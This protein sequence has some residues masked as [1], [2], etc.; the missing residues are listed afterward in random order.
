VSLW[1]INKLSNPES[2][3]MKKKTWK[4]PIIVSVDVKVTED[5]KTELFTKKGK[6]HEPFKNGAILIQPNAKSQYE[7]E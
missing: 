5:E 1:L 3:F 4:S 7:E 6:K 2:I